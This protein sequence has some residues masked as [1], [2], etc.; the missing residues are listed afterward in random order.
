M[1]ALN[2]SRLPGPG[3][4]SPADDDFSDVRWQDAVCAHAEKLQAQNMVSEVI[5]P[6]ADETVAIAL[7]DVLAGRPIRYEQRKA[8]E[9][10]S[11]TCW[12]TNAAVSAVY[13][14]RQ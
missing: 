10:L 8:L 9:R 13:G 12:S 3:D 5:E 2:Y 4:F 14:V 1:A 11:A 7:Q 6:L